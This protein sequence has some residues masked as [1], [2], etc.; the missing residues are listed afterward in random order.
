MK[1]VKINLLMSQLVL[2]L[3]TG[4]REVLHWRLVA[5]Y[6][7]FDLIKRMR[8]KTMSDNKNTVKLSAIKNKVIEYRQ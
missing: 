8:L 2:V 6:G 5:T 7:F 3:E 4:K 1:L